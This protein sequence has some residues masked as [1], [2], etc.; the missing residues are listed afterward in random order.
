MKPGGGYFWS[1]A[2]PAGAVRLGRHAREVIPTTPPT[3][4][5]SKGRRWLVGQWP[6]PATASTTAT[7]LKPLFA[8]D[9]HPHWGFRSHPEIVVH[10]LRL[11]HLRRRLL[12]RPFLVLEPIMLQLTPALPC[13]PLTVGNGQW[14]NGPP[15]QADEPRWHLPVKNS[16]D[17][18]AEDKSD[19]HVTGNGERMVAPAVPSRPE[20]VA[21]R[22]AVHGANGAP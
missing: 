22:G 9:V 17:D 11:A 18:E 15:K 3:N 21:V 10:Q 12:L 8:R 1:A 4:V 5:P 13:P 6:L 14:Q 20:T 2:C 19:H 7:L 16:D